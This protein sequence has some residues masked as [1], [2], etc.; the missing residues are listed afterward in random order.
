MSISDDIHIVGRALSSARDEDIVDILNRALNRLV[1]ANI[2]AISG[3]IV[4]QNGATS[5]R[6]AS[7]VYLGGDEVNPDLIPADDVA[8]IVDARREL[9]VD[10]FRE[11]Y[12]RIAEAKSLLK[13]GVPHGET[14]T[15]IT[16]GLILFAQAAVPFDVIADELTTLN[17][18]T[19]GQ[20]WPDMIVVAS[21]GVINFAVQFPG[22]SVSGDFLPPASNAFVNGAPPIYIV[23]V[24]RPTGTL[25]FNKMFAFLCAHL[26]IFSPGMDLPAWNQV[27]EGI[28]RHVVT[29]T[30]YQYN[31]AGEIFAVPRE[32]Y[33]DRYIPP[34]PL[35]IEAPNGEILSAIQFLPWQDGAVLL[36]RGKLPIE[37]LLVF[38]DR[39]AFDKSRVIRRPDVQISYVLPIDHADFDNVISRFQRQSNMKIRQDTG[40]FIVQKIADEGTR[41]PFVARLLLGVLKVRNAAI[42]DDNERKEF[43][44]YY[45]VLTSPLFTARES[46][47]NI[48]K[49]WTDHAE[50]ISTG[51]IVEKGAGSIHIAES[52]DRE[53]RREVDSFLNAA[54]RTMKNGLQ[55]L[56]MHLGIDIGFMFKKKAAFESGIA[57]LEKISPSLAIYLNTARTWTEPLLKVRNDLEHS[58]WTLDRVRYDP[59]AIGLTAVEPS[60]GGYGVTEFSS[61]WFDRL[62]CFV[63]E[64][65]VHCLQRK[66][67]SGIT[68]S[69]IPLASRQIES[70]ERFVVSLS[71]GGLAP[72]SIE[73]HA[74]RFEEV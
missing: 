63:E 71:L 9:T 68:V 32:L 42:P 52:I 57:R 65:S 56:G 28:P 10:S 55:S 24:M 48:V 22:E 12:R 58:I 50:K 70:P 69:E 46:S 26:A 6:F 64:F 53:L 34:R 5:A 67:P 3:S 74:R 7:V 21:T 38:L 20:H 14:R 31:V 15:N 23:T 54:A 66:F 29:H 4:D 41:S 61:V 49:I 2:R 45:E 33:N 36:L 47:R 62:A 44:R 17:S 59:T 39:V 72:W 51:V 19:P 1:G 40:Q 37:S 73:H 43:D 25:A 18:Q 11:S 35:F 60:I 27:V 16:L 13:T 8:A 30:G